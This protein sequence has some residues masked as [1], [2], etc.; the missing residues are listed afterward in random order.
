MMVR[1]RFRTEQTERC[2]RA[3]LKIEQFTVGQRRMSDVLL[4]EILERLNFDAA[5][6]AG[7]D[8]LTRCNGLL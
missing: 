5:L 2:G 3:R 4:R 6:T 8:E 1:R 7:H